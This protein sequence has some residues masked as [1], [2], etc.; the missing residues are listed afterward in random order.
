MIYPW[1]KLS[2]STVFHKFAIKIDEVK[3][4]MPNKQKKDFYIKNENPAVAILPITVDNNIV[5]TK[6]YRPGPDEVL[7]EMPGGYIDTNEDALDAGARELLEETG[8]TGQFQ[9]VTECFDGAYTTMVRTALVARECTQVNTQQ[10]DDSEYIEICTVTL[11]EFRDLLRSGK[12]TDIEIGYLA[13][14]FLRML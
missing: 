12:M 2:T 6:Q 13:L 10:L 11:E 8:Y 5:L 14:D 4:E 1:K 9:K 3:F 7:L